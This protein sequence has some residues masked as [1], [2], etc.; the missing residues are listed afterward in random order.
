MVIASAMLAGSIRAVNC[1]S[2]P[3]RRA[4]IRAAASFE[5]SRFMGVKSSLSSGGQTTVGRCGHIARDLAACVAREAEI[6]EHRRCAQQG[7]E[8]ERHL[9]V[10]DMDEMV[11]ADR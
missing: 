1:A 9:E 7:H 11:L 8:H 6:H 10:V 4:W 2:V 5:V 3:C